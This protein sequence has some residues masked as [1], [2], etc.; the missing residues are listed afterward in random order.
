MKLTLD[1]PENTLRL[2]PRH[3]KSISVTQHEI[4]SVNRILQVIDWQAFVTFFFSTKAISRSMKQHITNYESRT[5]AS[6]RLGARS[7]CREEEASSPEAKPLLW[8]S[9][10]TPSL[11]SLQAPEPNSE[12]LWRS[13][14]EDICH[15]MCHLLAVSVAV[16]SHPPITKNT[17]PYVCFLMNCARAE[18]IR[19]FII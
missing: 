16:Y 17:E 2:L 1:Q 3:S 13:R 15:N 11:D 14:E 10:Y 19:Y 5:S 4:L 12:A 8:L 7:G 18:L 9:C 6:S